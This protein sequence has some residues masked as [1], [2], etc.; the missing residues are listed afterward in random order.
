MS[1]SK[2][3]AAKKLIEDGRYSQARA[4]LETIDHPKAAEW[5][6]RLER[7]ARGGEFPETPAPVPRQQPAQRRRPKSKQQDSLLQ[8]ERPRR[9]RE[10]PTEQHL[11]RRA[12]ETKAAPSLSARRPTRQSREPAPR[13]RSRLLPVL[14]VMILIV[15]LAGAAFLLLNNDADNGDDTLPTQIAGV[16]NI[17]S[18][19]PVTVDATETVEVEPTDTP[20]AT[21][22]TAT[23]VQPTQVEV[24]PPTDVPATTAAAP[25]ATRDP[26]EPVPTVDITVT[27]SIAQ[28]IT[29]LPEVDGIESMN[30]QP[31][32]SGAGADYIV[33]ATIRVVDGNVSQTTANAI[34]QTVA[35]TSALTS[36][37]IDMSLKDSGTSERYYWSY[38]AQAWQSG[39]ET[40]PQ[41]L[42]SIWSQFDG[43]ESVN[44]LE[45][46]PQDND[47]EFVVSAILTVAP[48]FNTQQ[49]AEALLESAVSQLNT[50][51][52]GLLLILNEPGGTST[53]YQWTEPDGWI[54][55][56]G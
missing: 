52:I 38:I 15:V 56:P 28:T 51:Q 37:N 29:Q 18:T 11:Q 41:V 7:L 19:E 14:L 27:L 24:I 34:L 50:S 47:L 23:V 35:D 54:S 25:I 26:S 39:S 46:K 21:P 17:E 9:T 42:T 12:S 49:M 33:T 5:L 32:A 10:T 13:R 4:L 55:A 36:Y 20:E 31:E 48:G 1:K 40:S 6:V 43:V 45:V 30:I 16:A 8:S 53:E 22:T 2:F 44:R 3:E